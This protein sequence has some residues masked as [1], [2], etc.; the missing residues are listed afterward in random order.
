MLWCVMTVL[1]ARSASLTEL[2]F[3]AF[4][5]GML[6]LGLWFATSCGA[7]VFLDFDVEKSCSS[8]VVGMPYIAR[9][10][11]TSYTFS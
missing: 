3:Q 5:S 2:S 8:V 9:H 11:H 10:S 6:F 1:N 4:H 7:A